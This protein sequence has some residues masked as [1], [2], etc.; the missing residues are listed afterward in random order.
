[1]EKINY[2]IGMVFSDAESVK[3]EDGWNERHDSIEGI[4]ALA[5][6]LPFHE[7]LLFNDNSQKLI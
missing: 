6:P 3:F 4:R 2:R 7:C 1:M 5:S